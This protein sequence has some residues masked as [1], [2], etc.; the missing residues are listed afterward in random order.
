M[1]HLRSVFCLVSLFALA[2]A[3]FA[4]SITSPSGALTV[5][6]ETSGSYQV[7]AK[8]PGWQWGG[9]LPSQAQTITTT[10]DKDAVGTYQQISFGFT[11]AGKPMTAWIRLYDDKDLLLFSQTAP[12]ARATPPAPFPNFTT[13]PANL[14]SF[15]Y[16]NNAFSAPSFKLEKTSTPWLFF[17]PQDDALLISP[18]S[19]FVCASMVGDGKTEVGSG[20]NK[21]L[22]NLPAGFTQQTLVTLSHGINHAWD[23][24]GQAMTDLQG[25]ARP[26]NDA[27]TVLKYYGYWTDNG[28]AYWYNYDLNK[29]YQATLQALVDSYRAKQI[30]IHYLQLDSWWYHKT[31]TGPDGKQEQPKNSKLPE[32]DWNRYGG[33][34][35]YKAH[36]FIFPDGMEAFHEK[37]GL[38][39]ITHNRWTDPTSPYHD[40]YKISGIAAVDPGFWKEIIGYIKA[41]GVITYE[42]DWLN[43]IIAHSPELTSTVDQGDAFF[44]GMANACKEDG[45]TM[46]YCMGTPPAFLQGSK[47]ANLTTIRV[48]DDRFCADRYRHFLFTSRM[49]SALGMWPWV[50]VFKS[51]EMSNLLLSTLSAGP[52]GTGDALGKENKANILMAVRAD[53]VIVKPDVPLLPV[54]SSY[55]SEA[56]HQNVPLI[57]TTYTD[58]DGIKT[59]Y[60]VA[61]KSSKT[62]TET[63]SPFS[64]QMGGTGSF[65]YYDYFAHTGQK[66]DKGAGLSIDLKGQDSFYFVMAPI[67]P[68]GMAFLGD[69][70]KLVGTG[71]KRISAL[72][73]QGGIMTAEVILA[74]N[75][76]QI[77]LQGYAPYAPSVSVQAGQSDPVSYDASTGL[78]SVRVKPDANTPPQTVDGDLIRKIT[79]TFQPGKPPA[80]AMN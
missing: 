11:D 62:G 7:S 47:Y 55:L 54:D 37:V 53:G 9:Q 61:V 22:S 18:A 2:P 36:P 68:T 49:A 13:L 31:L 23:I 73:D 50:D 38:P 64:D 12:Q 39:F 80:S 46:Q 71:K 57:A 59:I 19:H 35:E 28:A 26:A 76:Q 40:H 41:N 58:H 78:F 56:Q 24:W 29:G 10:K 79:V 60:G 14:F 70:N 48:N 66:M 27:D 16:A 25:K 20:F 32:G 45:L 4:D 30:P 15:S 52:V 75:E 8:A 74:A 42:Q 44:D 21:K 6:V 72:H 51:T 65:Y 33:T 34:I 69:A 3:A 77:T 63:I 17:N 1:R 5:T 67:G 43:E